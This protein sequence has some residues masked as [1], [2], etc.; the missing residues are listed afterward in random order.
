MNP[1]VYTPFLSE[2]KDTSVDLDLIKAKS[3]PTIDGM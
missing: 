2:T 1:F 3:S